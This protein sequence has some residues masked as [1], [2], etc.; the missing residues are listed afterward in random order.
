MRKACLI[1]LT[2]CFT[3][4]LS[5]CHK[6]YYSASYYYGSGSKPHCGSYS[7][8]HGHGYKSYG[9]GGGYHHEHHGGYHGG[10]RHC[11]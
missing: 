7:S 11:R 9:Y 1:V 8:Y 10:G 4:L 5:G 2:C 6:G 3:L